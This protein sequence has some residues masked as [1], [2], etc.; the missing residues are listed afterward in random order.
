MLK[1]TLKK[2]KILPQACEYTLPLVNIII[3]NSENFLTNCSVHGKNT[4]NRNVLH[5]GLLTCYKK[6]VHYMG[7]KILNMLSFHIKDRQKRK[8]QFEMY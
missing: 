2:F 8:E 5:I 6:G 4:H 3:N 1:N 7:L